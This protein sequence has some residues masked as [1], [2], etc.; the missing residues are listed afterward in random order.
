[1]WN[2]STI[3]RPSR[4]GAASGGVTTAHPGCELMTMNV[5]DMSYYKLLMQVIYLNYCRY[6]FSA[7]SHR[8]SEFMYN[9][10]V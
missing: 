2:S 10:C 6:G 8:N 4:C 9:R 7:L 1:M 5:F 3:L